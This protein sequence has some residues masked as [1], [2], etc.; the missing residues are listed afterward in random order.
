MTDQANNG[1]SVSQ[2]VFEKLIDLN[3]DAYAAVSE[4]GGNSVQDSYKRNT[5][6]ILNEQKQLL[7]VFVDDDKG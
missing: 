1:E 6:N 5:Q 2:K 7:E 3:R 4:V